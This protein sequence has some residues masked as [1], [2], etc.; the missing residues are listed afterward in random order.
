MNYHQ[1]R[2]KIP[3]ILELEDTVEE[4]GFESEL[5][6]HLL[7]EGLNIPNLREFEVTRH[8]LRLSQMNFGVDTGFYPL[9]KR[10]SSLFNIRSENIRGSFPIFYF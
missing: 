7:R 4:E 5:P 10:T 1:A 6:E 2:Y 9:S 8:Y 3:L